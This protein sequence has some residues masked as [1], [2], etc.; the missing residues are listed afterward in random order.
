MSDLRPSTD[1][2]NDI[3]HCRLRSCVVKKRE[4]HVL[5]VHVKAQCSRL[6]K[7]SGKS[8]S[9]GTFPVRHSVSF[10]PPLETIGFTPLICLPVSMLHTFSPAPPSFKP[11]ATVNGC[12]RAFR[13]DVS[14]PSERGTRPRSYRSPPTPACC[15]ESGNGE[16]TSTATNPGVRQAS[17]ACTKTSLNAR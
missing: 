2:A 12:A 8:V 11:D 13:C 10:F 16:E 7:K 5:Q 9:D 14:A 6:E 3:R 1:V 4:S 15:W 17:P